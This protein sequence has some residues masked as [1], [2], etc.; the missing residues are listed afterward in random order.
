MY[1]KPEVA[2]VLAENFEVSSRRKVCRWLT[3][4]HLLLKVSAADIELL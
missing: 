3:R 2:R 4:Q 1:L